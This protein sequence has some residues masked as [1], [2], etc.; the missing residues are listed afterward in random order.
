MT[1]TELYDSNEELQAEGMMF[2]G[3]EGKILADFG[4]ENPR[5]IPESKMRQVEDLKTSED[6]EL[7]SGQDEWI[8]AIKNGTS[9]PGSFEEVQQLAEATCL[10]N[11]AVRLNRRLDWDAANMTVTN[12]PEANQYLRREYRPGWEL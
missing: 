1:P 4:C 7:T 5:L 3:D 8:K 2:V 12:V 10:G 6:G 9:S 11:L